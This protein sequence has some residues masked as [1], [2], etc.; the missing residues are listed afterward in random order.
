MDEL[1]ARVETVTTEKVDWRVHGYCLMPNHIHLLLECRVGELSKGMQ[2]LSAGFAQWHNTRYEQTGHH[3]QGRFHA[4][5]AAS[6]EHLLEII[7]YIAL[8]P[9]RAGLCTDPVSWTW[10]SYAALIGLRPPPACLS[11]GETLLLFE[12]DRTRAIRR[13][14][15][16]VE[17]EP[18]RTDATL[19]DSVARPP[20]ARRGLSRGQT[21]GQ[22][23]RRGR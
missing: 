9:V 11:V 19:R 10:S 2:R 13:V 15:D 3:F 23:L 5:P 21:P 17:G 1:L 20:R 18:G 22:G 12:P 16:F 14:R 7:R 6:T 4:E 8:N